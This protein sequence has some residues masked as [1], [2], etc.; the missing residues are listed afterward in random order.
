LIL[1]EIAVLSTS[2]PRLG[3]QSKAEIHSIP[4]RIHKI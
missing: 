2:W 3:L 1:L 4:V